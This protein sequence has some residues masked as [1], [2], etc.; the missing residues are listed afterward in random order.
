M[1][2]ILTSVL[3]ATTAQGFSLVAT[4]NGAGFKNESEYLGFS[5]AEVV[6]RTKHTLNEAEAAQL[7]AWEKK[8]EA[9]RRRGPWSS[10][11]FDR[12]RFPEWDYACTGQLKLE[13]ETVYVQGGRSPR[14]SFCDAK[15]QRLEEMSGEIAVGLAVLAAAKFEE[16][17]RREAQRRAYEDERRRRQEMLR[18]T[19]IAGRRVTALDKILAELGN[20]RHLRALLDDLEKTR[21]TQDTARVAEFLRWAHGELSRREAALTA[22]GLEERFGA[23]RLFGDDDDHDFRAPYY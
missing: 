13:L 21:T 18:A 17:R 2:T 20:L 12:P 14:R 16:E 11:G 1:N 15:I 3:A 6:A 22:S 7:E 9:R 10:F 4:D 8:Q 23:A 19:H 5:I